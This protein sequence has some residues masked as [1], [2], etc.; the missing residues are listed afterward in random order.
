MRRHDLTGCGQVF[1]F[2][3]TQYMK[4]KSVIGTMLLMVVVMIGSV[5]VAGYTMRSDMPEAGMTTVAIINRTGVA[6]SADDISAL[7]A[8]FTGLIETSPEQAGITLEIDSDES[9]YT[10]TAEGNFSVSSLRSLEAATVAALELAET[11]AGPYRGSAMTLIDYLAPGIEEEDDFAASFTLSYVY[12]VAVLVLA[13]LSATYIIRSVLEEKASR[14]VELLLISVS[15]MALIIGKVL[16]SMCLVVMQLALLLGGGMLA[17]YASS[18]LL[19]GA[20]ITHMVAATGVGAL[21]DGVGPFAVIAALISVF[22]AF[23][24]FA[25][26]GGLSAS[27]CDSM[28]DMNSANTATVFAALGG[29][30][31]SI[32]VSGLDGIAVK[33]CALIP[34]AS[35]YVAPVK[36]IEGDVGV[37]ILLGAWALQIAVI[38][39]LAVICKRTYAS[40]IMH[41]GSR[42]KLRTLLRIAGIGGA[43]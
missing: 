16:A 15:P 37:G 31:V 17:G 20:G 32:A 28:D 27:C 3:L 5:F 26:I 38:I 41:T 36:F 22:L 40:L 23:L 9:G 18:A 19:G 35:V 7:S 43:K 8:E 1:R 13:M 12:A 4:S 29:Y 24:T 2:T 39:A 42:V 10:V 21:L 6:V 34:F 11:G 30:I 14:L 25:L 33:I